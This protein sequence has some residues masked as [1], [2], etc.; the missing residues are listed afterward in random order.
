M[1][2][3]LVVF[4][5]RLETEFLDVTATSHVPRTR[6]AGRLVQDVF[7]QLGMLWCNRGGHKVDLRVSMR[8]ID[9]VFIGQ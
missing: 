9:G 6:P 3:F 8:D 7:N 1:L 5:H 4:R 2:V